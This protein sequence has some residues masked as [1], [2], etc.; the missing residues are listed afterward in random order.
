M[1]TARPPHP[2]KILKERFLDPLG[3]T[4]ERLAKSLGVPAR[5]VAEL[6]RGRRN[7]T[8]ETAIR[9][10]LF[11]DVPPIWWIEMQARHDTEAAPLIDEIRKSVT[12]YEGLASVLV[13][14]HG[15][16]CPDRPEKPSPSLMLVPV[17]EDLLKRLRAQAALE[18]PRA[19]RQTRTVTYANG[20]TAL[21]GSEE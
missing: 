21:V 8:L 16:R 11:F 1:T 6:V 18:S 17:S 10:G 9:L 4:P 20:A 14:P 19:P 7:M 12:P 13:T 5:R 15:V 3:I 2:G